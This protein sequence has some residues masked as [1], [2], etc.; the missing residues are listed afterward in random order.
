MTS[1]LLTAARVA[2]AGVVAAAMLAPAVTQAEDNSMKRKLDA[3]GQ[4]YEIDND[5]DFK[6]TFKFSEDQR[7]QIVFVSGHVEEA[8]PLMIRQIFAPVAQ[9]KDDKIGGRALDLLRDNFGL[10]VGAYEVQGDFLIYNVK[11]NDDASSAQLQKAINMA[12]AV[13]DEKEK[14]ISGARDTF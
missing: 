13:A 4:K 7:T 12:A 10:K 11:L 14:E 3:L 5:G 2:I 1:P 8:K 9:V 6:M